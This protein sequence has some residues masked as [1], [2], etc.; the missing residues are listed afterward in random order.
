MCDRE[1]DWYWSAEWVRI[2]DF[3]TREILVGHRVTGA[4]RGILDA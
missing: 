1:D 2:N 3:V 4:G